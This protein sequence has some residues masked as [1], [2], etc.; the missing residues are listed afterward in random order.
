MCNLSLTCKATAVIFLR[1]VLLLF[2]CVNRSSLT[3]I[4]E[5]HWRKNNTLIH[6]FRER[7]LFHCSATG[8][9]L[10][11]VIPTRVWKRVHIHTHTHTHTVSTLWYTHRHTHTHTHLVHTVVHTHVSLHHG[12]HTHT[13]N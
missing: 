8:I 5:S 11:C 9:E 2:P 12:T 3:K 13:H 6:A 7:N 10:C 4:K 1:E